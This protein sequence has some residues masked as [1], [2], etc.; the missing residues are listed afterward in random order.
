MPHPSTPRRCGCPV[1]SRQVHSASFG[2]SPA[3]R[4]HRMPCKPSDAHYESRQALPV[5]LTL[6]SPPQAGVSKGEAGAMASWFETAL[7]ASSP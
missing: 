1:P 3:E 2:P 4:T 6:P 5:R 7:R